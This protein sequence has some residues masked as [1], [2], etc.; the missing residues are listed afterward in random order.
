MLEIDSQALK[1]FLILLRRLSG[2]WWQTG[3]RQ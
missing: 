2:R 3:S 1:T